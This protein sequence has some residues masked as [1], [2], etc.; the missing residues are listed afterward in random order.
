MQFLKAHISIHRT[1][2]VIILV[3]CFD[4][5]LHSQTYTISGYVYDSLTGETLIGANVYENDQLRGTT[6]NTYGFFSLT[7]PAGVHDLRVKFLGYSE[8]QE[9]IELKTNVSKKIELVSNSILTQEVVIEA[10]R[11]SNVEST[12]MSVAK[13]NVQQ[14]KALPAVFGEVDILKTIQL[15]PGVSSI[16]EGNA[17]FYV[18][19]G[20]PDQ[21]LILLDEAVVY[22]SS[23]LFGFFSVFNSDAI[24]NVELIKG[25]MPANYGGRLASV[26]DITMNEGN[27]KKFSASGGIGLISSRL[28]LEGP[29]KKDTA[30]FIISARRTYI[31]VLTRP[32]VNNTEYKGTGYYFYDLN[33]KVNWRI[34][35][36]DRVFLSG[37]FGKDKF[38]FKLPDA[39]IDFKIPWGNA[40]TSLRWN[41]LFSKKIFTNTTATFTDYNFSFDG[42]QDDFTFKL[43]SG[44]RDYTFKNDWSYF[45]N[46]RHKVKFGLGYVNH[47][48]TPSFAEVS[49]G[50]T[51]F[52]TGEKEQIHAHELSAYILDE[53]DITDRFTVNAGLRIPYFIQTGPF[54]RYIKEGTET[55]NIIDYRKGEHVADYFGL[56]PRISARYSLNEKSSVKAAYTRNLQFVHLASFSPLGLPT[57]LWIPSSEKVKPQLGNQYNIGYFRNLFDNYYEASVELYYKDLFNQIEY[58]EGEQPQNGVLNNV[59]NQLTFGQGYSYGAEFFLKRRYGNTTGWIGYTWSQTK[60]RFPDIL[61][62]KEFYARYDR[63]HDLSLAITHVRNERWTFSGVFVFATGS[64]ITL[65]Q[66]WYFNPS[67]QRVEFIYGARN[68][69]RMRNF[70][71]LD[72]SAT[73]HVKPYKLRKDPSSGEQIQVARKWESSWNFGIYNSYNRAN[74]FFYYIDTFGEPGNPDFAFQVKQVSLFTVLPSMAWNFKF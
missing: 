5:N 22:N 15:L 9:R 48:Y 35:E 27:M 40:T 34:S 11:M 17:G 8:F 69:S 62:G 23:H 55:V 46:S 41:H 38:G 56:E 71:R 44:I 50:G 20:G 53:F 39:N 32:L 43:S 26:L 14:V 58:K 31:D 64:A 42:G 33:A 54:K 36:K 30:S 6:S 2:W 45:P 67:E 28:T 16:G 18:R 61:D 25:G 19:G 70:H 1:F 72:L 52:N 13:L 10:E 29:I 12:Q 74:P 47:T 57:D 65:P 68:S 51:V 21:N 7:L 4:T 3:L 66:S 49:F 59:D 24:K 73:Y 60:R 37:Y 63:R